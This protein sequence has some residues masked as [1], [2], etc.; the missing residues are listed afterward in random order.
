MLLSGRDERRSEA[1]NDFS[2]GCV[3]FMMPVK[4]PRRELQ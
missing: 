2:L 3:E 1:G 4:H